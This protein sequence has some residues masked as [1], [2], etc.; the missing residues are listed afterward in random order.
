MIKFDESKIDKFLTVRDVDDFIIHGKKVIDSVLDGQYGLA[1]ALGWFNVAENTGSDLMDR[2]QNHAEKIRADADVFILAG[3][4]GSNRAA[5]TVIEGM[6][7]RRPQ[8]LYMG[9]TLSAREIQNALSGLKGKSVYADIIAKNFAT[10]EPALAFRMIRSWMQDEYGP[11]YNDR[12]TVTG[13][14]DNGQL[15]GIAYSNNYSLFE[16]PAKVGGRFSAFTAVSLLPMAIMGADIDSFVKGAQYTELHIKADEYGGISARYAA[17]RHLLQKKGFTVE[18]FSYFEPSLQM[19]ARWLLQLH[20][21][22][23]GKKPESILPTISSYSEDLHA[24]GQYYQEGGRFFFE[25]FL[26]FF[27]PVNLKVPASDFDDGLNYLEGKTLDSLNPAVS[28]AAADAHYEAGVP[29]LRFSADKID[30]ETLGEFMYTQMLSAYFSAAF[31]GVEP[32]DQNG[33]ESY[34]RNLQREL[35]GV[36]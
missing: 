23:E 29:V 9:N 36:K 22:T 7:Y 31:L 28:K 33:V 1:D 15:A 21:E 16:F 8:I 25:T 12:I 35:R 20:A 17:I 6:E 5:Q 26:D 10:L 14:Y 30:E 32:F 18:A 13:S 2:I 3:V 27:K 11:S 4:G 24:I 34:K 19:L